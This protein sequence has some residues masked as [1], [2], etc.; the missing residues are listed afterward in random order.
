M[1]SFLRNLNAREIAA[2]KD[3]ASEEVLKKNASIQSELS[4]WSANI[5]DM[6]VS[7]DADYIGKTLQELKWRENYGINIAYIKRGKKLI[8]APGRS[9]K[10]LPFDHA[11]IIATDDQMQVFKPVFESADTEAEH[12]EISNVILQKIVVDEYNRLKGLNIRESR[13]REKTSGLVIGIERGNER[14]L[15]PDSTTIF[16]WDDVVWLVADRNKFKSWQEK[17]Q[18]ENN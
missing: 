15:N 14:I 3:N 1:G 8:H 11:G 13:I 16:E 6:E 7:P 9:N 17:I 2:L 18:K 10:L 4:P 12:S 5:I